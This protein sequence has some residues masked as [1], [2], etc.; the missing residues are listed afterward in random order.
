M[1]VSLTESCGWLFGYWL[2]EILPLC[3]WGCIS[4]CRCSWMRK[5]WVPGQLIPVDVEH[6]GAFSLL[7]PGAGLSACGQ[8][9]HLPGRVFKTRKWSVEAVVPGMQQAPPDPGFADALQPGLS[10]GCARPS[11]RLCLLT[12][13]QWEGPSPSK[14]V[15]SRCRVRTR[16]V[17]C[18]SQQPGLGGHSDSLAGCWVPVAAPSLCMELGSC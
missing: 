3:I 6:R 10:P 13:P 9:H 11:C 5:I 15:M 2:T 17:P 16:P 14:A 18:S 8:D 1:T 12:L 7:A 4:T